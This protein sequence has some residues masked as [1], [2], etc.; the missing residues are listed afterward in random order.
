MNSDFNNSSEL[1]D[2]AKVSGADLE[3]IAFQYLLG[4]LSSKDLGLFEARLAD[5][6]EAQDALI[7]AVEL[8]D[9]TRAAFASTPLKSK[10][11]ALQQSPSLTSLP[12]TSTTPSP[13]PVVSTSARPANPSG[14]WLIM[15][16]LLSLS[17]IVLLVIG[18]GWWTNPREPSLA[19]PKGKPH[20]TVVTPDKLA[21][22]WADS[23]AESA[24][25][26]DE[27]A[28][29]ATEPEW[30]VSDPDADWMVSGLL[31]QDEESPNSMV[32]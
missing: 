13:F 8:V 16:T 25:P 31:E 22:V 1:P 24:D 2:P 26:I 19:S 7:D 18:I 11:G 6:L 9:S 27:W 30:I 3:W 10:S 20:N 4:E 21:N 5:D 28:T 17:L 23:I 32:P 14:G 15:G 12:S 29:M